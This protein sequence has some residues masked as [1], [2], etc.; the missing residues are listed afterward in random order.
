MDFFNLD[1]Q[2]N[3]GAFFLFGNFFRR[4]NFFLAARHFFIVRHTIDEIVSFFS[5]PFQFLWSFQM[6]KKNYFFSFSFIWNYFWQD[7]RESHLFFWKRF[8]FLQKKIILCEALF[9]LA[10]LVNFFFSLGSFI[11]SLKIKC[12]SLQKIFFS[13]FFEISI[14]VSRKFCKIPFLFLEN[15]ANFN[16][17]FLENFQNCEIEILLTFECMSIFDKKIEFFWKKMK[18]IDFFEKKVDKMDFFFI[19]RTGNYDLTF[20]IPI[21]FNSFF[22]TICTKKWSFLMFFDKNDG[23]RHMNFY[24]SVI[25]N[26]CHSRNFQKNRFFDEKC[27]TLVIFKI[28]HFFQFFWKKIPVQDLKFCLKKITKLVYQVYF[29]INILLWRFFLMNFDIWTKNSIFFVQIFLLK[30][31]IFIQLL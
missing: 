6:R 14:F 7:Y 10:F 28:V 27:H 13:K 1:V 15:F 30:I 18:K 17:F 16:F 9:F 8:L 20:K 24:F 2:E 23:S 29:S 4:L 21:F 26:R 12:F 19:I 25:K 3:S 11:P 5:K 31:I 22:R